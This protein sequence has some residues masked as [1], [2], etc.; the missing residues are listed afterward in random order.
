VVHFGPSSIREDYLL[1]G[2]RQYVDRALA[3]LQTMHH[4]VETSLIGPQ[5]QSR[6]TVLLQ[7][8]RRDFLALVQKNDEIERLHG[9]MQQAAQQITPLVEAN[10][11]AAQKALQET[12]RSIERASHEDARLMV[13]IAVLATLL[14]IASALI[15]TFSITRLLRRM[16][17]LLDQLAYEEPVDR[18]PAVPGA[19]DEVN[20]MAQSVNTMADHRARFLA[21]WKSSM[22]EAAARAKLVGE[23]ER[24]GSAEQRELAE[25]QRERRTLA[26]DLHLEIRDQAQRSAERSQRLLAAR[27]AGRQTEECRPIGQAARSLLVS[28]DFLLT[29]PEPPVTVRQ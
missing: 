22:R 1:R 23:G 24:A 13:W 19:R 9:A 5:D 2:D 27:L 26:R 17:G 25:A 14:G 28:A 21:W 4:Q 16:A 20:A 12:A 10:V 3:E 18:V 7:D 8:Y 6:L 11:Q 29:S 15:I